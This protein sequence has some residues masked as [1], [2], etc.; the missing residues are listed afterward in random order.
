MG[1]LKLFP[2]SK[3]SLLRL[4]SGSFTVDR[5]GSILT[6]TL[7][8]HFPEDLIKDLAA[9]V[10]SAFREATQAQVPLSQLTI[11]YPSLK[12]TARELRGGAM[13]FLA[14][15]EVSVEPTHS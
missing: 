7:P 15:K 4:P 2:D 14:P 9:K 6:R 10:L 3:P 11:D 13:V 12:I 8:S 1:F 5:S